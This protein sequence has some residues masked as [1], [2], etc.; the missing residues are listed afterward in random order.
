MFRAAVVAAANRAVAFD[1]AGV[2][3][4]ETQAVMHGHPARRV[5]RG[6]MLRNGGSE[7]GHAVA[8]GLLKQFVMF[9][10]KQEVLDARLLGRLQPLG[11]A[12]QHVADVRRAGLGV[13]QGHQQAAVAD[14][15]LQNGERHQ[16]FERQRGDEGNAQ[17]VQGKEGYPVPL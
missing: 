5:A 3:A 16:A 8:D 4:D 7:A 14:K 10:I 12:K 13:I 11:R 15:L 17:A 6:R 9:G 1:L 2:P